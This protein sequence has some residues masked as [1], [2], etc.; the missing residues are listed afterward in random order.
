MLSVTYHNT[1]HHQQHHSGLA[2]WLVVG[3]IGVAEA[4]DVDQIPEDCQLVLVPKVS[5]VE[6]CVEFELVSSDGNSDETIVQFSNG[7]RSLAFSTGQRLHRSTGKPFKLPLSFRTG[8]TQIEVVS[9]HIAPQ[10]DDR[11]TVLNPHEYTAEDSRQSIGGETLGAWLE[12]LGQMQRI[13]AGSQ[14]LF[15]LAAESVFNPGGFDG[16]MVLQRQAE[17]WEIVASHLPYADHGIHFRAS[18]AELVKA[19]G[20]AYFHDCR[21][22]EAEAEGKQSHVAVVCP[23]FDAEENVV[24]ALYGFRSL[25]WKNQRRGIRFFEARF[26]QVVADSLSAGMIRLTSEARSAKSLV[27]L[28]QAFPRKIAAQLTSGIDAL[29]PR[30]QEVTVLFCDMRGFSPIADRFSANQ[31]YDLLSDAMDCFSNAILDLSGVVIDF[32]GDGL[33]AFWNAP[34]KQPEH[35]LL[36]CQAALEILETLAPLN[37]RWEPIIGTKLEVG[38]GIHSGVASVGNSGSQ[39]RI[40]YGPRGKNVNIASRLEQ[41]TKQCQTPILISQATA[42]RVP[43]FHTLRSQGQFELRGHTEPM[44]VFAISDHQQ[45]SGLTSQ[46]ASK[47]LQAVQPND[48]PKVQRPKFTVN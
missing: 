23:I 40:K 6:L 35:A 27:L 34:V 41:L 32:Y 4:V 24:A 38:I 1:T 11:L 43:A 8:T 20:K 37:Q 15:D 10:L 29:Q 9:H 14:E 30:V 42:E 45:V 36:A 22:V 17:S 19:T 25:H 2:S 44:E 48:P 3:E 13:A 28:E 33:S 12:T 21:N 16:C 46:Q 18:L 5:A 47:P 7:G 39:S 31:T 26:V